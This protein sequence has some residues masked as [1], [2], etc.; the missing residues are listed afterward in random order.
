MNLSK[1]VDNLKSCLAI[2][3]A[4]EQ[5]IKAPTIDVRFEVKEVS[6]STT[7]SLILAAIDEN[8]GSFL[9]IAESDP[10]D[11]SWKSKGSEF[12]DRIY[13]FVRQIFEEL[14][15]ESN[16]AQMSIME[17]GKALEKIATR[18]YIKFS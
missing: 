1:S 8:T 4:V 6:T 11:G 17:Q 5:K 12:S 18:V 15:Y 2:K 7:A 9:Y 10:V 13:L 3:V 14:Q 16:V